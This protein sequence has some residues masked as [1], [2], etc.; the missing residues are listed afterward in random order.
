MFLRLLMDCL[1]PDPVYVETCIQEC[2][3]VTHECDESPSRYDAYPGTSKMD[4]YHGSVSGLFAQC[5]R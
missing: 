5:A 3:H 4:G 2:S 1:C